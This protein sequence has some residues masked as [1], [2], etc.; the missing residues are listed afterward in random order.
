MPFYARLGFE[1]IPSETLSPA[2]RSIVQD[3]TVEASIRRDGWPCDAHVPITDGRRLYWPEIRRWTVSPR[4]PRENRTRRSGIPIV[5]PPLGI[6]ANPWMGRRAS[7]QRGPT[8]AAWPDSPAVNLLQVT[9]RLPHRRAVLRRS[10]PHS[11]R[12]RR[13]PR[14]VPTSTYASSDERQHVCGADTKRRRKPQGSRT[15]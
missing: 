2:L 11:L 12:P 10:P 15:T 9:T 13:R 5:H 1:V 14:F 6:H 3:G 4:S 7:A 8:P